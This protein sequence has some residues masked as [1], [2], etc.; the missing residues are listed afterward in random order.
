MKLEK[1]LQFENGILVG[2]YL[3]AREMKSL[4]DLS[5]R[6]DPETHVAVVFETRLDDFPSM[7]IGC[8][9]STKALLENN[10][11]IGNETDL[12]NTKVYEISFWDW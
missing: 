2:D 5:S 7:V 8:G 3:A 1:T 9:F 6:L 10:L 4:D 11:W 12:L